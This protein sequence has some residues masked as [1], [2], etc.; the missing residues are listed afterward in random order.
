MYKTILSSIIF[1]LLPI[2]VI[3]GSFFVFCTLDDEFWV[4]SRKI[5]RIWIGSGFFVNDDGDVVTNYHVIEWCPEVRL[6]TEKRQTSTGHVIAS[7]EEADL[8]LLRTDFNSN[9]KPYSFSDV[10]PDIT[11]EVYVAGY[12][13]GTNVFSAVKVNKGIVSSMITALGSETRF[14]FDAA[15]QV[16]NSGGPVI[17][18]QGAVV[19]IATAKADRRKILQEFD[20]PP[21][22]ISYGIRGSV[23]REF[24]KKNNVTFEI[25]KNGTTTDDLPGLIRSS[26]VLVGCGFVSPT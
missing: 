20:D 1:S 14:I 19:G 15:T 12:P 26:T 11:Q 2:G 24:L 23:L 22:N 10:D 3:V 25:L 18:T 9:I 13:F 21:E 16:G 7:D 6:Q 5:D 17:N 8:V 4:S